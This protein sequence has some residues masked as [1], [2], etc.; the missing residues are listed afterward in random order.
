MQLSDDREFG[1]REAFGLEEDGCVGI[2]FEPRLVNESGSADGDLSEG[3][4]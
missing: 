3:V 2:P 1:F 4:R